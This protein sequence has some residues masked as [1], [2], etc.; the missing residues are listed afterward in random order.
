MKFKIKYKNFESEIRRNYETLWIFQV[1]F[2]ESFQ[3][4]WG[5]FME[6]LHKIYE[7]LRSIQKI[8]ILQKRVGQFKI[9]LE[10]TF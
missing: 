10:H 5:N 7:N 4:F 9:L 6:I 8:N 1:I 3:K 2:E